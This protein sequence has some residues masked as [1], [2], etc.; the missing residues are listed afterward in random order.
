MVPGAEGSLLLLRESMTPGPIPDGW[1]RKRK[2][3]FI[4]N[5]A[6]YTPADRGKPVVFLLAGTQSS[7]VAV[8][9]TIN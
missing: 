6:F 2:K 1:Q 8:L 3:C 7:Q 9:L 5:T 4:L